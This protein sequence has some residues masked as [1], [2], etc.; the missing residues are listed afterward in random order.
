MTASRLVSVQSEDMQEQTASAFS[1]DPRWQLVQRIIASKSFA[2]SQFL[3]SFLLYVCDRELRGRADEIT[4]HQ[5][6]I[7]AFGRPVS[8]SP[9][10]DNIVR[11][12]ARLLRKRLEEYF[13]TE[14]K[15]ET[16]RIDIPR[17]GYIPAFFQSGR[18][19]EVAAPHLHTTDIYATSNLESSDSSRTPPAALHGTAS[20]MRLLVSAS[21]IV[22]LALAAAWFGVQYLHRQHSPLSHQLW[23]QIFNPDRETLIIPADSGFGIL[24]NL[25]RHTVRLNDYVNGNYLSKTDAIPG[26]D[27]RNLN[28]LSTQRYT[29]VVDLDIATR[30]ARVPELVSERFRIRYA[31]DLRM[32]DLKHSNAVL[33][34]SLHTNPWVEI[35]QKNMNFVLEYQP[36]VD[37]SVVLNRNPL[38]GESAV[39][40]N[41][42]AD[43][44]HRTYAVLAFIPSLDGTGNV[45]VVEGLNM[46][47][48]QA[49]GDFL[50]NDRTII[51]ILQKAKRADGTIKP[52]ELLLE[53][54][55]VGAN[56]PEAKVIAERYG[57]PALK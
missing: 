22:I 43:E 42:W 39:Y 40:K 35:F 4:E 7:Q 46:A 14:G 20:R 31:R 47:G 24:Q 55:S 33:L 2:R 29:S 27:S 13:E 49:A 48:T 18:E 57:A 9:G 32:E 6:G 10:E 45:I 11:N 15:H 12:Y 21:L 19:Q 44:S 3:I 30:L 5:I 1:S 54:S 53:T 28:D 41:E 51:P 23:T 52:F 56:A 16:L 34:G 8:Y 50:L 38:A 26:I 25:T 37:D 17:G 36:D